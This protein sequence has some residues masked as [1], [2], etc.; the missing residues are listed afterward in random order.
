MVDCIFCKI[1]NKTVSSDLVY[2]DKDFIVIKDINPKAKYHF[3][4]IPKHHFSSLQECKD[5]NI[6]LLGRMLLIQN[7]LKDKFSLSSYKTE[8]NSG[9]LAGQE[10]M[11]LHI[12]FLSNH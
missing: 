12:H 1:I 5:S 10:V 9:E 11:H 3:L 2:D 8:I 4:I 7:H 6:E